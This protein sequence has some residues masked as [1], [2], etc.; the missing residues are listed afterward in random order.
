MKRMSKMLAV[1]M[2]AVMIFVLAG[3]DQGGGEE[4]SSSEPSAAASNVKVG[5]IYAGNP[6][7]GLGYTFAHDEGIKAMQKN[8]GLAD[9]QIV[10]KNDIADT[11]A[12]AVKTA[13]TECVEEG[14]HIIFGTSRGYMDTME[15]MAAQYPDVI[16]SHCGGN[17][18]NDSN[19]N[20]YY[21]R[22]EQ[23]YYLA[24]IAAGKKTR[25]NRIG[26]VAAMG[27]DH[28]EVTSAVNAFALGAESVNSSAR[29][30]VKVTNTWLDEQKESAAA[31]VLL[32]LGCD[33]IAQYQYT[34]AAQ[35]EAQ[36]RGAWSCG[37]NSD[38]TEDAPDAHLT[39]PI[40]NWGVYYTLAVRQVIDDNWTNE[41]YLGGLKEGLVDISALSSNVADGT[42]QLIDAARSQIV[43]GTLHIFEGPI[44]DNQGNI[45]YAQGEQA[46]DEEIASQMTWYYKT[47]EVK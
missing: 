41:N 20:H 36:S 22:I 31:Q 46:T 23:A 32:D 3:C 14:C 33:V 27:S 34:T 37:Y 16:F 9:S 5:V 21:G 19:F 4:P 1:L 7:D 15:E 25:S 42:Q 10:R 43:N 39:A 29:V 47:V 13:I 35:T 45:I 38:M 17:K 2:A 28:S 8:L 12:A 44:E 11:D 6:S 30:Y 24:G 18:S 40:W 26:Y